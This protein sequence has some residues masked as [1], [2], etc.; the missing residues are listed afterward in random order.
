M[1]SEM[2][3]SDVGKSERPEEERKEDFKSSIEQGKEPMKPIKKN[4]L[5]PIETN[6]GLINHFKTGSN[7]VSPEKKFDVIENERNSP[8]F[9]SA[10][11]EYYEN[12]LNTNLSSYNPK[13]VTPL[14]KGS[15]GKAY[16]N[17]IN[18]LM[19]TPHGRKAPI[20]LS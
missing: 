7:H 17:T 15:G 9:I 3:P 10:F 13:P 8:N 16:E 20:H 2:A 6:T 4:L 14:R 5:P 1:K 12:N 18:A 19:T 11:G